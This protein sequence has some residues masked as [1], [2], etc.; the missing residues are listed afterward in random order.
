[1]IQGQSYRDGS[2]LTFGDR[3][4]YAAPDVD[5]RLIET[6]MHGRRGGLS[7]GASVSHTMDLPFP[8]LMMDE[9]DNL[10]WSLQTGW[11]EH[12]VYANRTVHT[13]D[14]GL[15]TSASMMPMSTETTH[16]TLGASGPGYDLYVRRWNGWNEISMPQPAGA[17][18]HGANQHGGQAHVMRQHI[19]PDIVT[20]SASASHRLERGAWTLSGRVGVTTS[21]IGDDQ[22]LAFFEGAFAQP[23]ARRWFVPFGLSATYRLP[24]LAP[25][26]A[27]GVTAEVASEAPAPERLYVGVRRPAPRPTWTGNPTLAQ[28][29]KASVRTTV[30]GDLVRADAFVAYVHGHVTLDGVVMDDR[31]YVTYSNADALLAGLTVRAERDPITVSAG[32]TWGQRLDGGEPLAEISPL[33]AAISARVPVASRLTATAAAEGAMAQRR[34]SVVAQEE[35]SAAW[36]R[37]DAGLAYDLGPA[38]MTFELENVTDALYYRHLSFRRDPFSAGTPVYEPGRTIRLAVYFDI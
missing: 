35:P 32:Y 28:P 11:R 37:F 23:A 13:M 15:R 36:L 6:S 34:V 29:V 12:K 38:T 33:T 22:Q 5:Y 14:N 7:Y 17:G 21:G 30:A 1:M 8:Y 31:R 16:L 24:S 27:A 20:A 10:M 19:I 26:W 25:G 2:N 9:R 4:G 18:M 3:Y